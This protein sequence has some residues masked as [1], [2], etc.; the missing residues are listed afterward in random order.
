MSEF[1]L[2]KEFKNLKKQ[3]IGNQHMT[4]VE[5][6]SATVMDKSAKTL[7]FFWDNAII[8]K[9]NNKQYTTIR[10]KSRNFLLN[11]SYVGIN[12]KDFYK[13]GFIFDVYSLV[14]KNLNPFSLERKTS[15]QNKQEMIYMLWKE[16]V[17]LEIYKYI[18]S[19]ENFLYLN[20]KTCSM[21]KCQK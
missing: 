13:K 3:T 17:P 19:D 21:Q 8:K 15:N 4:E 16:R 18:C 2:K 1:S 10:I 6:S 11:I 9:E 20:G 14:V 5:K 7:D 12:K